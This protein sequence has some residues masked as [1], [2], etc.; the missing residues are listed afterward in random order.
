MRTRPVGMLWPEARIANAL[1]SSLP[2]RGGI[3][4]IRG[5]EE[6]DEGVGVDL[7]GINCRPDKDGDVF[8]FNAKYFRRIHGTS[9]RNKETKAARKV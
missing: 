4:C 7:V 6:C 8:S 2:V 5:V 9:E 3:Y 1:F